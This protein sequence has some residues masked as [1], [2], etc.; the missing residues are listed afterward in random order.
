M[1]LAQQHIDTSLARQSPGIEPPPPRSSLAPPPNP[2]TPCRLDGRHTSQQGKG[3]R[4]KVQVC[5]GSAY[6]SVQF[7]QAVLELSLL[8]DFY[9]LK[10]LLKH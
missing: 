4:F 9:S 3:S 6:L 1:R 2:G 5:G 7:Q 8:P 10:M